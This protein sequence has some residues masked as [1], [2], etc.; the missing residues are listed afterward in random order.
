VRPSSDRAFAWFSLCIATWFA[1]W[2]IQMVMFSWLVVGPLDA[3]AQW[4]GLAQTSTML[5]A[6][7]LVLFGGAAADRVDPRGLL[8][9]LHVVAAAPVLALAFAVATDRLTLVG[10]GCYGIAIGTISA[11]SMPARDALLSRV[12]GPDLM[13]A[14]TTMTAAQFGAQSAGNLFAASTRWWGPLPVLAMQA[15]LLLIGALAIRRVPGAQRT[16]RAAGAPSALR[17]IAD[18]VARVARAPSLRAPLALVL[19]VGFFFIGPFTVAVPLLVRDVY[20]GGAAEI[21]L[22][23]MLF[24][25]GTITG[26]LWLRNRGLARKGRTALAALA[27]SCAIQAAMGLGLPLPAL[28]ALTLAWGL[29]GAY[30]INANRTLYQIAAPPD[31]RARVLAVYQLGFL[32]GAPLG[33]LSGGLVSAAVGPEW[34]LLGAAACMLV[35]VTAVWLGTGMARME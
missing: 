12:A 17:E 7:F 14:V 18:G 21:S 32:G 13:R 3:G 8:A 35:V 23:F 2:G 24:P 34:M 30:F 4:L 15:L 20:A 16:P 10:L 26:S 6:L 5:P 28:M 11:F 9:L 31:L 29:S 25:L 19:A 33:A 27:A 1:A 22:V